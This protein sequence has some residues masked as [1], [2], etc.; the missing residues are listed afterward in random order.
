MDCMKTVQGEGENGRGYVFEIDTNLCLFNA[1]DYD[2]EMLHL[3]IT[4][5]FT[6]HL[7]TY[8][9]QSC[10]NYRICQNLSGKLKFKNYSGQVI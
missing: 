3:F 1:N 6:T 7:I 9:F 5:D 2:D 8:V 4:N 10:Q